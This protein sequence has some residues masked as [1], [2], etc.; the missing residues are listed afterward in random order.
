MTDADL[1]D[2]AALEIGGSRGP[3]GWIEWNRRNYVEHGFGLWVIE[4]HAGDFIGDCGLT[5]QEVAG[6]RLVEIGWHVRA[7]DRRRGYAAE[8]G[9]AVCRAAGDV[10]IQRLIA[11]IRPENIASQRVATKIGFTLEREVWK[12][13]GPALVFSTDLQGTP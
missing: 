13:G 4:T 6:D 5:L 1:A 11:I 8:A 3:A 9:A 2:I 7:P 12:N 10:G